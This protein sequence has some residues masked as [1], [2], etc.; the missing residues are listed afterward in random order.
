MVVQAL[1]TMTT[2]ALEV[3]A[4]TLVTPMIQDVHLHALMNAIIQEKLD[5]V[6]APNIKLVETMIQIPV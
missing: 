6:I 2:I 3:L 1:I 4:L 5:V